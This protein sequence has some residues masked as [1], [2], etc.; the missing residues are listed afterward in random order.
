MR[1]FVE[2]AQQASPFAR[3]DVKGVDL[4]RQFDC[5]IQRLAKALKKNDQHRWSRTLRSRQGRRQDPVRSAHMPKETSRGACQRAICE[6]FWRVTN[7]EGIQGRRVSQIEDPVQP[8][9]DLEDVSRK[10]QRRKF[11]AA[12]RRNVSRHLPNQ[13]TPIESKYQGRLARHIPSILAGT[14]RKPRIERPIGRSGRQMTVNGSLPRYRLGRRH[15][16]GPIPS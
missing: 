3:R 15:R 11:R 8:K 4:L 2:E 16:Y 9:L 14:C 5:G 6:T 10:V 13:H 1:G 7:T 12:G